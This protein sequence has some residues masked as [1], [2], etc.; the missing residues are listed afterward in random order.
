MKNITKSSIAAVLMLISFFAV[1]QAPK[2]GASL[3]LD[4]SKVELTSGDEAVVAIEIVRSKR[5]QKSKIGSPS[6][7]SSVNGL[8]HEIVVTEQ[9]DTY[10]LTLV[11]DEGMAPGTHTMVINGDRR[12]GRKI[13]SVLL[14]VEVTDSGSAISS[15][16]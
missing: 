13:R 7:A 16:R 5:F 2:D 10:L 1:A 14:M 3:K 9:P 8:T 4:Q 6:L 15:K 11:A 12:W